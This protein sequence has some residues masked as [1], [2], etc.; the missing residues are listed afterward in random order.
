[1]KQ[2]LILFVLFFLNFI[3]A[4]TV[5]KTFSFTSKNKDEACKNAL[6]H[7]QQ[8]AIEEMGVLIESKLEIKKKSDN[9]TYKMN[10]SS[11]LT[12]SSSK[13]VKVLEKE[14]VIKYLPQI[15]KFKC[16]IKAT[17]EIQDKT[18]KIPF[19]YI[20]VD[21]V[22]E[23]VVDKKNNLMWL[24]SYDSKDKKNYKK[25]YNFAIN[26]CN[27]LNHNNYINW[28]LPTKGELSSIGDFYHKFTNKHKNKA[29]YWSSSFDKNKAFAVGFTLKNKKYTAKI[30][31]NNTNKKR[32]IRCVRD[33]VK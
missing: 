31:P 3:K 7:M 25:N 17:L 28:R 12:S 24:D 33:N 29:Y 20:K 14:E 18:K 13:I 30:K 2:L 23:I 15:S 27:N 32:Y 9:N 4:E 6:L 11:R 19:S 5:N 16:T 26:Y 1:M 22:N 8:K 10:S 21:V